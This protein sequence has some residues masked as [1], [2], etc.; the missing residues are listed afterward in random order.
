MGFQLEIPDVEAALIQS[1]RGER[2]LV[3]RRVILG[4]VCAALVAL[5]C[6]SSGESTDTPPDDA[7]PPRDPVVNDDD[8]PTVDDGPPPLGTAEPNAP[9]PDEEPS[10]DEPPAARVC[11]DSISF[12]E[13]Y[14]RVAADIRGEGDDG[15]FIRYVSLNNR[16][17]QG[18]C[19][20]DLAGDRFALIKA[21]NSLSTESRIVVPEA[22]DAEETLYRID[23]R[24]FGWDRPT[25]VG[26]VNF[27]DKWEAILDS[28]PL[29][30]EFEGD[31]A[32]EAKLRAGTTVPVLFADSLIDA[33][34]VDELYYAL[35]E[36]GED[37]DALLAQLGIDEEDQEER[38]IVIKAGTSQSELSRQDM[39]AERLEIELYQGYYW[40][41][42]DIAASTAG[43]S[44]FA[45]PLEFEQDSIAAVFSLPNGLNGYALFDG[46]G[47]RVND[48]NVVLDP[49]QRDDRVRNSVSCS[50]CHASG[51]NAI[52]DEVRGYAEQN[53][54]DYGVDVLDE[55]LDAFPEQSA[56]DDAIARDTQSFRAALSR[57]GLVATETDPISIAYLRYDGDVS[58]Q[59]AAGELGVTPERFERDLTTLSADVDPALSALRTQKLQREQFE[60]LYLGTLCLS[61]IAS[62][63][64]PLAADC[65]AVG[66]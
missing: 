13:L 35:I 12:D 58:L 4:S 65:A 1:F 7:P 43:Q 32:D 40:G 56:I 5:A 19:S 25:T 8:G 37:E 33:A 30:V 63:N 50:Q 60:A 18:I 61:Q 55:V 53:P 9:A 23:L 41:R 14:T 62:D 51:L 48:T 22:I 52:S 21:V 34:M 64:R 38:K 29:A 45:D 16:L 28:A 66:Q 54:L 3:Q 17:N 47:L 49:A 10:P 46:A 24:Q 44:I 59:T 27:D 2:S 31:E 15:L 11:D 20:E 39:V 36:V 42:Y 57:L 26:G 6:S